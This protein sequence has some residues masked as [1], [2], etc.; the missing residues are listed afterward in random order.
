L[1]LF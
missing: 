1:Y